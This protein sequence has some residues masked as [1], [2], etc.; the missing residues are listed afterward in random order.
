MEINK[1]IDHTN[2]KANAREEDIR[3][4]C[5]EAKNNHF[6]SVCVNPHFVELASSI[7]E[8]TQVEVCTVIGF[9]L[10]A[11]TIET[12]VYEAIN[13]IED[14]ATEIDMVIN[15]G[16]VKDKDYEYVKHEIEEVRNSIDGKTLKVI[17][18]TC[19]LTDEEIIKMTEI[20][21]ET[22]VNYIKTSTGFGTRGASIHDIE[23]INSAKNEILEIKA[24]G[25]IKT[26][27]DAI[28]YI[29][30]GVTRI[31]T[32]NGVKIVNESPKEED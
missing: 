24:S 14:G 16:A 18:E 20:C 11:N 15:I 26:Y 8:D 4:L 12:K 32:S 2:L 5:E 29:E 30:M 6:A 9:P 13:A 27:E 21:N 1:Y 7:L 3:K 31:G 28:K 25:G 10:G 23:L 19:Y 17:I 22:F